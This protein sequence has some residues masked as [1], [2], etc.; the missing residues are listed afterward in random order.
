MSTEL[1]YKKQIKREHTSPNQGTYVHRLT[2]PVSLAHEPMFAGHRTYVLRKALL[3][4]VL[5]L[6]G[7]TG[8]WAQTD[9]SGVY[10]IASVNYNAGTPE[11]NYYLCPTEEW[12]YYQATDDFTGT[13]N[14]MPFLTT[15]KCR[16]AAYH[17]GNPNDAIWIIEKAPA[18]N[19]SYYYI[20]QAST[21]KYLTS[22]GTI[23]TTGNADRM[24]IHLEAVL[25]ENLDDKE[26]FTITKYS[27]YL[28]ISPKGVVG[29]AADRNWL[30]VNGG[31]KD[32]LQGESG[33]TGGPTGYTNTAGI[34][35]VYTQNDVNA[36]FFLEKA[37]C[38]TPVITFSNATSEVTITADDDETIYYTTDGNNPDDNSDEYSAPF[39]L[40]EGKVIK[41]ISK[42]DGLIDSEIATLTVEKLDAPTI[43]FDEETREATITAAE[44]VE[45]YYTT[46]DTDPTIEESTPHAASPIVIA[47][48][49]PSTK[50]HAQAVKSGYINSDVSTKTDIPVRV[51]TN[52]TIILAEDEFVYDGSAKTPDVT[53]KDDDVVVSADEY[54]VTYSNN[55]N[56]GTATV[57]ITDKE[58]GDYVIY[59]STTFT[60]IPVGVTLTANSGTETY[61]GTEKTVTGFTNS[62]GELTFEGI[63]ASGS[64]TNAGEY[65]V[66]F[67]G[68]TINTTTDISGNYVVTGISN[69]TL[70]VTP[71]ELG[72]TWGETT[73]FVY[74]A[75]NHAP[76]AT[77]TGLL[78]GDEVG[79]NV[80]GQETNVGNYTATASGLTGDKAD[81]YTLTTTYTKNFSITPAALSITAKNHTIS[82]GDAPENNGVAYDGFAGGDNPEVLDGTLVYA[83]NYSQYDDVGSYTIT[84]SGLTSTNYSITY[85]TGTL[86]VKKKTIV[87]VWTNTSF[88]YD[89]EAHLPE[90]TATGTVNSEE[91]GV[92]VTGPTAINAG[93]YTATASELTGE[94]VG[95]YEL[96]TFNTHIFTIAP[97]SLGNGETAAEGITVNITT[98]GD[99][100]TLNSVKDGEITLTADEDYTCDIQEE[101]SDIIVEITGIGNYT[102]GIKGVY[103]CPVFTDPEGS[104]TYVAAYLARRDFASPDG[105]DAYIVRSVNPSVGTLTISKIEYIPEDVPVLLLSEGD[106]SGF[107]AEE[108]DE[109]T[110][111]ISIGTVNSN[112]LK[113]APSDGVSVKT[114]EVYMFYLGEFVLTKAGTIK[115]GNFYVHNPNFTD[116]SIAQP[117]EARSILR[118]VIEE[119]PT[120][121]AEYPTIENTPAVADDVW[122]TLDGR[123]LPEKPTKRGLYIQNGRKKFI[124]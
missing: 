92:T 18:P 75:N 63:S 12:C 39:E 43:T 100:V 31:N 15:Y 104:G 116:N 27:T 65:D 106:N 46:N 86:T 124:K 61:D 67:T 64:G 76:T 1:G 26:L 33:K 34:I 85:H 62:V 69:G 32:S 44:G 4:A 9:Y 58:G 101:A 20:R 25:P 107:L 84:P 56:A 88:T 79:V 16:S 94:H 78:N 96:P 93:K 89:C 102:G 118:M 49:L 71:K 111:E 59:G 73:T 112:Q 5:I 97:K 7:I 114:A 37:K 108:K 87:L 50:I 17:S 36:P 24:R 113:V 10:Y 123:R 81:N 53:V 121:I 14:G 38:T 52:P 103:I 48:A 40:T 70:T 66:T 23:Q 6:A 90:A 8:A 105:V 54:V 41:A 2:N 55:V 42:K 22:N 122:Y 110:E 109:S 35:G 115:V 45:I 83:Y 77:L 74:D 28:T 19:S 68:V 95:H 47:H 120:D 98:E 30:T 119:D 99:V 72:L 82:Y 51:L 3:L 60:I 13:N 57:N 117:S 29:G 21:G 91:I 80:T 11:N